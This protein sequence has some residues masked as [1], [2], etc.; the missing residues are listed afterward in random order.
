MG[1]TI[2]GNEKGGILVLVG[3]III[4]G[5]LI[6]TLAYVVW[7]NSP[8]T[9]QPDSLKNTSASETTTT[10]T[11]DARDQVRKEHAA[12]LA[13]RLFTMTY[14]NKDIP[15]LSQAGFKAFSQIN[16]Q[17]PLDDPSTKSPYVFVEDQSSMSIGEATFR[18]GASCDNKISGSE[19]DGLI[20]ETS[21]KSVAVAIKLESGA[22]ACESSL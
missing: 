13:T 7:G 22:Y 19:G 14:L 3:V 11:S 9:K 20:I 2:T 8:N 21:K 18:V 5:G 12:T 17:E 15:E 1:K 10:E 6:G 4:V 16:N